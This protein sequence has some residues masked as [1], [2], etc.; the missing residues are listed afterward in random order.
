MV[1]VASGLESS[2]EKQLREWREGRSRDAAAITIERAKVFSSSN[3]GRRVRV[4]GQEV[5]V[6]SRSRKSCN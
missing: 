1:A 5:L 3:E 4:N 6:V 2:L